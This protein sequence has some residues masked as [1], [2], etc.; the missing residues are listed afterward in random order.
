M[1]RNAGKMLHE[2]RRAA[3]DVRSEISSGLDDVGLDDEPM[4]EPETPE[5]ARKDS[6]VPDGEET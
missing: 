5:P 1:A 3:S 4:D 2:L 6:P